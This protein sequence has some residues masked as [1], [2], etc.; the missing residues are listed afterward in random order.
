MNESELKRLPIS[1]QNPKRI[2]ECVNGVRI[3]YMY[4]EAEVFAMKRFI[5]RC[6]RKRSG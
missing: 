3:G 2:L 4:V 1:V 6:S 5:E